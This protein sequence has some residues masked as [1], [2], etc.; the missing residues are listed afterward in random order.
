MRTSVS[1][2]IVACPLVMG[3]RGADEP[4]PKTELASLAGKWVIVG[5]EFMGKKATKEELKKLKG[6]MV[7]KGRTMTQWGEEGGKKEVVS[8][9]TFT[10]NPKAKPKALDLT[11]TGGALKGERVEAIYE[12]KGDTL[13][14]C[15]AMKD[16]KRPAELA[17]KRDGKAFLLIY[18]REK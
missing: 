1:L 13:R 11:Y 6:E 7:I 10:L 5:K 2:L 12:L 15:Y 4:E 8:E 14:V 16:E 18:K 17:G 9:A 3:V